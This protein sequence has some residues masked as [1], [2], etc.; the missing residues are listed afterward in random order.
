MAI[1]CANRKIHEEAKDLCRRENNFVCLTSRRFSFFGLELQYVGLQLIAKGPKAYGFWNA[2]MTL[3]LDFPRSVDFPG[4]SCFDQTTLEYMRAPEDGKPWNYI[5]CS[6]Q[7]PKFCRL[8]LEKNLGELGQTTLHV[9]IDTTFQTGQ[10]TKTESTSCDLSR[11]DELLDP[12]RQL[13]SFEVVHIQ[14]PLGDGDKDELIA[15]ICKDCPT[16]EAVIQLSMLS[17]D[18]ADDQVCKGHF[19]KA[20]LLYK[21]ALNSIRSRRMRFRQRPKVMAD[22]PFPGLTASE[23]ISNIV[24]RLHARIASV[25]FQTGQLRM[26]RIYTERAL[27]PRRAFDHRHNKQDYIE[28]EEWEGTV[29][30]E[31]LHVA[32]SISYA[33][34]NIGKAL[35]DLSQASECAPFDEEQE[36]QQEIWQSQLNERRAK[37]EKREEQRK[38]ANSIYS[39]KENEKIE[40]IVT[41]RALSRAPQ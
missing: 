1:L 6:S 14:G 23:A 22:G 38:E 39:R 35:Y 5:I 27:D 4:G 32:A 9:E 26:A 18:R 13:H 34:N 28:T 8:L 33:N 2:S 12:L 16:S 41:R 7:L 29:Y 11:L 37:N 31:V 10:A 30:A 17:L 20:N 24:V 36:S 3:T 40:G 21:A 19:T 15:S 25:Y